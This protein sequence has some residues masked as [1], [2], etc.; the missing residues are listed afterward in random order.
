MLLA[1]AQLQ[2]RKTLAQVKLELAAALNDDEDFAATVTAALAL[3]ASSADVTAAL[4]LKADAATRGRVLLGSGTIAN[5]SAVCDITL[6]S[7]YKSLELVA[8]NVE[9]VGAPDTLYARFSFDGGSSYAMGA[10]DYLYAAQYAV[11]SGTITG[12]FQ[13]GAGANAIRLATSQAAGGVGIGSQFGL[14]ISNEGG[15]YQK[16]RHTWTTKDGAAIVSGRGSGFYGSGT[17]RATNLRLVYNSGNMY[18]GKYQLYGEV[19]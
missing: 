5:G 8:E 2:A 1:P 13:S 7:G 11:S 16:V 3:K 6:P 12:A 18:G 14:L 19:G 9:P 10:T 4:A 17:L 15:F